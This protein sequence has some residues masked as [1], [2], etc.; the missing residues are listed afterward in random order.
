[1]IHYV[2][3]ADW[4]F[5]IRVYMEVY[6]EPLR[7]HLTPVTYRELARRG[8]LPAGGYVFTGHE[9]LTPG[10][11]RLA[12]QMARALEDA[13]PGAPLLNRPRR[14]LG[15][16]ALLEALYEE[17]VNSF[18]AVPAAE[19]PGPLRYP[20]F[21]REERRHSGN[22]TGLL[23]GPGELERSLR[24]LRWLGFDPDRLLVVEHRDTAD[25]R[26]A[27]RKYAAYVIGDEIVPK[28][29]R[30][31]D[32]WM[33]K[34]GDGAWTEER[35]AEEEA[36]LRANPHA[37]RLREVARLARVD[38]GRFDYAVG[39]EGLEIWEINTNPTV[40]PR[41][42]DPDERSSRDRFWHLR[43]P[44]K[45]LFRQRFRRAWAALDAR[46]RG[47]SAEAPYTPDRA[48]HLRV[49]GERRLRTAGELLRAVVGRVGPLPLSG[50][51]QAA[52]GAASGG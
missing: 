46:A 49:W 1:M 6:G 25:A 24:R 27:Y 34:A 50:S 3:P 44:G 2:V 47:S 20:V 26:G 17:G 21:V 14:P 33:V 9:R 23:A 37:D 41:S 5:T 22:L 19:A 16:G 10:E 7:E 13:A 48:L 35:V 38:Y 51:G 39:E 31:S 30:F 43:Q 18:R 12:S 15:R 52:G 11:R 45:R 4:A 42:A 28:A 32:H 8:A 29:V 40:G 36:Y